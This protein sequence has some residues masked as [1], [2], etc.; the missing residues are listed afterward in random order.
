MDLTLYTN[1]EYAQYQTDSLIERMGKLRGVSFEEMKAQI[2][3]RREKRKL[4]NGGKTPSLSSIFESF[5][6]STE[7]HVH[8][9]EEI[10]EPEK[11]IKEDPRLKKTLEAFSRRFVLGVVSNNPVLVARKTLAALGVNDFFPIII[12]QDTCMCAKPDKRP[13]LKFVELSGCPPETCVSIGDRYEI[14]LESPL[15]LGMGG[16]LVDGVEDVYALTF[17]EL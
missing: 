3:E 9:R 15:E 13:F 2:G 7:E 5:G 12:G 1:D 4:S 17:S 11:F 14:D 10:F 16:I 8:W 6:I